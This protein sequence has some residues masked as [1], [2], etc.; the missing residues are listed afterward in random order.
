[1]RETPNHSLSDIQ[2]LPSVM[3]YIKYIIVMP[4]M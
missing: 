3:F 4:Y 2:K 1:M